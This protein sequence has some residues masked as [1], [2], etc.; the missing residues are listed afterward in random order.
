MGYDVRHCTWDV[1]VKRLDILCTCIITYTN[2][3]ADTKAKL[4]CYAALAGLMLALHADQK[5]FEN[6]KTKLLDR[7]EFA[8][9][10]VRFVSF[11]G[12]ELILVFNP[13]MQVSLV[14]CVI[15][16]AANMWFLVVLW[17][18]IALELVYDLTN[19]F[20]MPTQI[21]LDINAALDKCGSQMKKG[22]YNDVKSRVA[23]LSAKFTKMGKLVAVFFAQKLVSRLDKMTEATLVITPAR[24]GDALAEQVVPRSEHEKRRGGCLDR[25]KNV[26]WFLQLYFFRQ[27]DAH[28]EDFLASVVGELWEHLFVEVHERTVVTGSGQDA[29]FVLIARALKR[30]IAE[31]M[32]AQNA[33]AHRKAERLKGQLAWAA[34]AHD[35]AAVEA[36]AEKLQKRLS[37]ESAQEKMDRES[38]DLSAEDL[39]SALNILQR[40]PHEFCKELFDAA[41]DA[42]DDRRL[43]ARAEN[44]KDTGCQTD[45]ALLTETSELHEIGARGRDVPAGEQ[46]QVADTPPLDA[47]SSHLRSSGSSTPAHDKSIH[48]SP[49]PRPISPPAEF[50]LL[51]ELEALPIVSGPTMMIPQDASELEARLA[52]W[53]E[54]AKLSIGAFMALRC[55]PEQKIDEILD[56]LESCRARGISDLSRHACD[57]VSR[58]LQERDEQLRRDCQ[59]RPPPPQ[60]PLALT[61]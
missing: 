61:L 43:E 41:L 44:A 9:L 21:Q 16:V 32:V 2:I 50:D 14:V 46:G 59:R 47:S 51:A 6:R 4:L 26:F 19:K 55:V 54:D 13:Y 7:M 24:V 31:K 57:L 3:A 18:H 35:V 33:P 36:P 22:V 1:I 20:T 10:A 60:F 38:L 48:S 56:E 45:L 30:I 29:Q 8:G 28:Q 52:M 42:L 34:R 40:I 37:A 15:I 23:N 25:I 39:N 5:P 27:T 12:V 11:T 49:P 58:V 53:G 17:L